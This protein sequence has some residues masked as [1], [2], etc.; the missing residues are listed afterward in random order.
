MNQPLSSSSSATTQEPLA[1]AT[2]K[3]QSIRPW[4]PRLSLTVREITCVAATFVLSSLSSHTNLSDILDDDS[5]ADASAPPSDRSNQ[6]LA[7]AQTKRFL[8]KVNGAPWRRVL[9]KVDD[10]ADEAVIII[11]SLLPGKQYD[12]EFGIA[13]G[14]DRLKSQIVTEQVKGTKSSDVPSD[15]PEIVLS[16]ELSSHTLDPDSS[17]P[18]SDPPSTPGTP[19]Q[20]S[21]AA[22]SLDDYLA[23]LHRTLTHLQTERDV[24]LADLKSARRDAHKSHAGLRAEIAALKKAAQK[25]AAGDL[26]MRQKARA[27]EEAT[28]QAVRGRDDVESTRA[29]IE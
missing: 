28:K 14:E 5:D 19:P 7:D 17:P 10:E 12:I 13:P 27:L 24:L 21:H 6:I 4:D 8:V 2:G 11:Y 25:H 15:I 23:T 16:S 1:S 29:R 20:P 18:S 9:A 3:W 22:Q 26:R